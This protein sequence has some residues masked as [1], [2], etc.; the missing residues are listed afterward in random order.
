MS[1]GELYDHLEKFVND[2]E[3]RWK[4]CIRVKRGLDD[5]NVPGGYGKDQCYLEGDHNIRQISVH[6][7]TCF[8]LTE[9]IMFVLIKVELKTYSIEFKTR[10]ATTCSVSYKLA[11]NW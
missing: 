11:G 4:H 10:A 2:K 7:V 8:Q 5:V 1:F 3:Q 9:D 6:V